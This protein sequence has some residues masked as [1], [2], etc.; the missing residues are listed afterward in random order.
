MRAERANGEEAISIARGLLH[1][2]EGETGLCLR[3]REAA[4]YLGLTTDALR[5]WELNGLLQV[6]RRQNGYRVYSGED[7]RRLKLIRALRCANY[8]LEAILRLLRQLERDPDADLRRTLNSPGQGEE[9]VS[10]CDRLL[11][12]LDAAEQNV[13]A[14]MARL[15]QM[16]RDY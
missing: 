1:R 3:R 5:N 6:K 13:H 8:S 14:I 2:E 7:L 12:S 15:E 4:Q 16:K 11:L 9:L 10:A